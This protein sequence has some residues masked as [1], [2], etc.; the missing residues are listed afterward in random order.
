[1]SDLGIWTVIIGLGIATYAIRFSFLGQ[2]TGRR[3][4]NRATEALGFV[5]VVVLP[6][7]VAPMVALAPSGHD[8]ADPHRPLAALV[9]LGTGIASRNLL[10]SITAGM[11]AYWALRALGI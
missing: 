5:P 4:P 1:M 6:A 11:S 8:W 3:I 2:L 7:I 10:L 9:A